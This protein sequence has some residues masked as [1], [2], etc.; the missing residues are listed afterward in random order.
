[1]SSVIRTLAKDSIAST[2]LT[3]RLL[4]IAR[5][6]W[7]LVTLLAVAK[8]AIGLPSFYAEKAQV[9]TASVET[10]SRTESPN[11]SQAGALE[12]AGISLPAYARAVTA[13][14][15]FSVLIWAGVGVLVF[16][17]RS[18]DWL[19]LIASAM[20]ISFTTGQYTDPIARAYPGLALPSQFIFNL[21]NVCCFSSSACFRAD[22]LSPAGCGGIGWRC[23]R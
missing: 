16:L 13:S 9:C 19:A 4:R 7:L 12:A 18:D 3:G 8:L 15:M 10:C 2:R 17:L 5:L 1:M 22:V 14:F 20:M 11:A 21:Q 23:V 6:A